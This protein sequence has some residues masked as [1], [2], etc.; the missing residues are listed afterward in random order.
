MEKS[1][2]KHALS[3]G[4]D[5]NCTISWA[6]GLAACNPLSNESSVPLGDW[7]TKKKK[8]PSPPVNCFTKVVKEG[9]SYLFPHILYL[10][11]RYLRFT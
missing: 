10:R 11:K 4:I 5:D 7:V 6:F 2:L 8:V 9:T 3:I 1:L